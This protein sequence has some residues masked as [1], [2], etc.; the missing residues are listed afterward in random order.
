M[1]NVVMEVLDI[2]EVLD[3][4]CEKSGQNVSQSKSRVFFSPHVVMESME[5]MCSLLGFRMKQKLSGWKANI[6]SMADRTVLIQSSL[7]TIPNYTM[8]CAYLPSKVLDDVLNNPS[9]TNPIF[10]PLLDDC[11]QLASQIPHIRFSHC[12]RESNR[13]ADYLARKDLQRFLSNTTLG[14]ILQE[15]LID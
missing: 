2:W 6:L 14:Y 10:S 5:D 4:F 12:Y 13:C 8:Q 3:I 11:K 7:S 15:E 1:S 9:Q